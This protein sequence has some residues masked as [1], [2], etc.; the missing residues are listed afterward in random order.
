MARACR[1]WWWEARHWDQWLMWKAMRFRSAAVV[2]ASRGVIAV[3]QNHDYSYHPKGRVG[4][5][6]GI[7]AR[8]K[9]AAGRGTGDTC[10]ESQTRRRC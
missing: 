6:H 8:R 4:V 3:H 2:D 1:R 5:W 7:E 10:G 9:L